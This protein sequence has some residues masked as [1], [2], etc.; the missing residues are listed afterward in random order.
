MLARAYWQSFGGFASYGGL[1]KGVADE[2]S[3][4]ALWVC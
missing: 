4:D 1:F 2:G 3:I